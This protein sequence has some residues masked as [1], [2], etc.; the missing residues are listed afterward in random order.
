MI[1][2][3]TQYIINEGYVLSDKTISVNLSEFES[4]K[5]NKLL[6]IGV[7]GSGKT[8]WAEH[9]AK[10]MK[11]KWRSID[12]MYY[13]LHKKYFKGKPGIPEN[14]RALNIM[15]R[16]EVIKILQGNERLIMEGVDFIDIYR[17]QP[18][19]RKLMLKQ[20]MILMGMSSLRGGI[21]GGQRNMSRE[22]GEGWRELYWMPKINMKELE[23]T[24][25]LLRKDAKKIPG[26]KIEAYEIPSLRSWI[27]GN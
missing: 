4:G 23:S 27:K 19:Y 16:K 14:K 17:E 11:V 10:R 3:I 26:A 7:M 13:A 9:L 1:D 21:R 20:S 18:G 8:T 24:L 15:V 22:G 12:S 6:V 25:K 5:N 2:P